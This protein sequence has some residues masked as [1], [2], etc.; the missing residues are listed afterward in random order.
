MV[1]MLCD[2]GDIGLPDATANSHGDRRGSSNLK[3]YLVSYLFETKIAP[4][5]GNSG[6]RR[7]IICT[8]TQLEGRWLS[9]RG[10]QQMFIPKETY[11]PRIFA[12]LALP[13]KRSDYLF[14]R[15]PRQ[16]GMSLSQ[17]SNNLLNTLRAGRKVSVMLRKD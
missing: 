6:N 9:C 17:F 13:P 7:W 10:L 16:P 15:L 11:L 2:R 4:V 12:H 3:P 14:Q 5:G 1:Q 8:A